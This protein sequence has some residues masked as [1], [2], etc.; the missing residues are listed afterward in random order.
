MTMVLV[1]ALVTLTVGAVF[2]AARIR[3]K[4]VAG[5]PLQPL[6]VQAF[7]TL[8]DRDDER[9]LR[10]KLVRSQFFKIKRQRIRVTFRYL[11]RISNNA[12]L[13]LRLGQTAQGSHDPE[14][15][16]AAA[17]VV[18]LATRVRLHCMIATVKMGLEYAF[19]TMQLRPAT[20]VN[21]YQELRENVMLLGSV[22]PQQ[23]GAVASSI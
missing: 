9:F 18:D 22:Q 11:D 17:R 14:V 1:I 5:Q 12:G 20:L 3:G 15:Q 7:H 16:R 4:R 13:V 6:D 21:R 23:M 8:T 2:V 19:P 10:E